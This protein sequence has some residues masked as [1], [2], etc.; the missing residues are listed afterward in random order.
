MQ[1][2]MLLLDHCNLLAY[3]HIYGPESPSVKIGCIY[4]KKYSS[5]SLKQLQ[6]K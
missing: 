6:Y 3:T 1:P 5:Q 2:G 4:D